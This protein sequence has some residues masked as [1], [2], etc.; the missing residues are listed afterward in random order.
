MFESKG[1]NQD[2]SLVH[3]Q[4]QCDHKPITSLSD[5]QLIVVKMENMTS[6]SMS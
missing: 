4:Q 2:L 3:L 5:P 1:E 6:I